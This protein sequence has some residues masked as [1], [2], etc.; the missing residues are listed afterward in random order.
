MSI[1]RISNPMETLFETPRL[2]VRTLGPGDEM[3][4]L[5][6]HGDPQVALWLGDGTPLTAP[7][8][9][10]WVQVSLKDYARRG[11]GYCA[12]IERASGSFVGGCGIIHAPCE[13]PRTTPPEIVYAI[14]SDCWG[15]GFASEVVPA[16]LN[17]AAHHA[18][19]TRIHATILPTNLPSAQVLRK[20]GLRW[21]STGPDEHGVPSSHWLWEA[22]SSPS[23]PVSPVSL[24]PG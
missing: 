9:D 16:M 10:T 3:P 8:C 17:W 1:P 5:V 22:A 2:R 4:L 13:P 18:G 7:M 23:S 19:L 24:S 12:V 6:L 11:Y 14:R 15:Q 21:L 20:A